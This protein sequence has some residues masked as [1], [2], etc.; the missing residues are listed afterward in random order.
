MAWSPAL[1]TATVPAPA[2]LAVFFTTSGA[3]GVLTLM[4]VVPVT[5]PIRLIPAV[6]ATVSVLPPDR[7]PRFVLPPPVLTDPLPPARLI[8]AMSF[9]LLLAVSWMTGAPTPVRTFEYRTVPATGVVA[10]RLRSLIRVASVVP[11]PPVTVIGLA[12]VARRAAAGLVTSL[13]RVFIW[14]PPARL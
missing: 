8:S 7:L 1:P 12:T 4:L 10:V 11:V 6:P 3:P 13:M 14:P 2:R 5:E 9:V